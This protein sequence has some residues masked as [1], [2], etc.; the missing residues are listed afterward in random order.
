MQWNAIELFKK[1]GR[2]ISMCWYE[3]FST[4]VRV[5]GATAEGCINVLSFMGGGECACSHLQMHKPILEGYLRICNSRCHQ[6]ENWVTECKGGKETF[7]F[8]PL[9]VM[10]VLVVCQE[11]MDN[12][13]GLGESI[14]K[15]ENRAVLLD[16]C[17]TKGPYSAFKSKET[18]LL[19]F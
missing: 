10:P 2:S 17:S 6:G 16:T 7:F 3:R 15:G 12:G 14:Q 8:L 4:Y 18:I 13:S 19:L 5:G 9:N 11:W 1:W